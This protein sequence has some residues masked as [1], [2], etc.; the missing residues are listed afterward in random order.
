MMRRIVSI[1]LLL[2]LCLALAGCGQSASTTSSSASD[3][4]E[5]ATASSESESEPVSETPVDAFEV[6]SNQDGEYFILDGM[7]IQGMGPFV[8]GIGWVQY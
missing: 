1:A 5:N 3:E 7:E 2:V 4:L 8:N 6:E